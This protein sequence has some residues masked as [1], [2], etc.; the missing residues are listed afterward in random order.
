YYSDKTGQFEPDGPRDKVLPNENTYLFGK[1]VLLVDQFCFSA[2]EIESYGFSQVPGMVVMGQFPTAG[3]E[4]ETARGEFLLP[5]DITFGVPTGRFTLPDGSIFL[6][7]QGVQ[8]TIRI[9]VDETSVLS[10]EDVVLQEAID[11]IFM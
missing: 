1:M 11:Y 5:E 4:A 7:G 3:V 9:P 8:P 2:C 10:G 6:E